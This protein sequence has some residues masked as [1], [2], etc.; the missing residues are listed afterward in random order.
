M[1]KGSNADG[2]TERYLTIITRIV[3][4]NIKMHFIE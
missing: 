3:E 1:K 2:V 4:D